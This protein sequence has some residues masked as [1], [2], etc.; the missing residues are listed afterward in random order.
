MNHS[1]ALSTAGE[2]FCWGDNTDRALGDGSDDGFRLNPT[3]VATDLRF[4]SI[5]AGEQF[6]C[7]RMDGGDLYCWGRNA[8]G[9]LG[10]GTTTN[11]PAPTKVSAGTLQFREI[12]AGSSFVCAVAQG[13]EGYCW[14]TNAAAQ[15]G[16]GNRISSNV[17][18]P[19][20]GDLRF[21]PP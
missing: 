20:R 12:S 13:G 18:T 21:G 1:C 6:T 4:T 16:T 11:R 5:T 10:D 2:A 14:G 9:Q 3:R 7:A 15:L 19:V 17:P 8:N